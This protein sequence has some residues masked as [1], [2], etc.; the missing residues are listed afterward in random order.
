MLPGPKSGV[1]AC[2]RCRYFCAAGLGRKDHDGGL[3]FYCFTGPGET[4]V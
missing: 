1:G 2:P 3:I 4:G